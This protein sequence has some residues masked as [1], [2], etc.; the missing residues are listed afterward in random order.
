MNWKT[1]FLIAW[2]VAFVVVLSGCGAEAEE[3]KQRTSGTGASS[4]TAIDMTLSWEV[5][6]EM[7]NVTLES[8]ETGWVAVGFDPSQMMQD[9][10]F[11]LAYVKDGEVSVSDDYGTWLTSHQTD[12]S[13]GGTFDVSDASG[14]ESSDGT[15][16]SFSIPL[17]SGDE[18]DRPLEPGK[19]YTVLLAY[20][21]ADDFSTVHANKAS[22][23]ITL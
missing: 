21:R 3:P 7:L 6:G 2:S 4:I 20:S 10:N 19:T 8:P 5:S 14:R 23:E 16:V 18:Y 17:D 22:V 13:L 1:G 11:I 15:T 12:E 9:A